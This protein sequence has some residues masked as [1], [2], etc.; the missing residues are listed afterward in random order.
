MRIAVV[1]DI[2][3]NLTAFEAVHAD[4]QQ[5]SPDLVLHGGDLAD[6]GSNPTKIIHR[7]RSLGWQGV[8]G[9]PTKPSRSRFVGEF[10]QPIDCFM[11]LS[12]KPSAR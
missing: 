4:I 10:R 9:T 6:S 7:L 5:A 2:H 3:G 12:G 8:M 1:S 11:R